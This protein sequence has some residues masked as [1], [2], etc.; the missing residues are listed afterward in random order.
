MKSQ[1]IW[2]NVL[3]SSALFALPAIAGDEPRSD[4]PFDNNSQQAPTLLSEFDQPRTDAGPLVG[5]LSQAPIESE[6]EGP[7]E[8]I[9]VTGTRTP[10]AVRRSP[11]TVNVITEREIDETLVR[12]LRDLFRYEPNIGVGANRRYG[13]QDITIRGLGSN[14]VLIQTDGIR[15]PN[16][17]TFGTPAIGRDYIELETLQR[18]EVIRGPA[19]ALY[20]SDALGGVVTFRTIEPVDLLT[21]FGKR[22]SLSVLSTN[23][24][25]ADRGFVFNGLTAHRVGNLEFL[26]GYTRR[27]AQEASIPGNSDFVDD[28][29]LG[30]NNYLGKFV[31]RLSQTS[32]LDFT[33]ERFFNFD[34]FY[35]SALTARDLIGP[36]GFRGQDETIDY[37]TSRSR[38]SLS[39]NF[40]DPN[41]RGF[42]SAAKLQIYYQNAKVEEER[43]QDFVRT[44]AGADR[45]R[46]RELDNIFVDRI[47][48]GNV[49]LQSN[50]KI[51]TV[52]NRLTYGFDLSTTRNERTRD[53]IEQRFNAAG[54]R[55]LSTTVIGAD[56]FPV[57][58]FPDSDTLR[59]GIYL[60][61]EIEF[62]NTFTL[63][64]GLRFDSYRLDT[65]PDA[66]YARNPG[67][68]AADFSSSAVSPSVGFV[69]QTT[70][71]LAI[72]GRYA[73]GF[74]AP[75]YSEIN[76]G[77]TNLT[78]PAFRYK[79]LSNPDL[80]PETSNGFEL[81]VR[82][83]FSQFNFSL[84]GF[85]NSYDNFIERLGNVGQSFTLVPG[86]PVT[87]FQSRNV[88][89]ARTYGVE[90]SGQ[91]RFSPKPHGLSLLASLGWT[92]GDDLT[93]DQPLESVEP[94]K[95]V[96]GLRYRAPENRWGADLVG[97]FVAQP[98]LS[99]NRPA[100]SF[101]P[102]AYTVVDLIGFYNLTPLI[103]F[104]VG[105]FNLFN[106]EYFEYQD[107]RPLL[108]A[109]APRDL[110]RYAQ[111]GISIR[112]GFT[113][114]F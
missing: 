46:L 77:F 61:N 29:D 56:N 13:I 72:V 15:A 40:D 32:S 103:S 36:T 87:L 44:G 5:P 45:R 9:T 93:T 24:E 112:A 20:G 54:S 51:G 58:D 11:A 62:G 78:S 66:I 113:Y 91:Y 96:V 30:R 101:T 100:G 27:D 6:S 52:A 83:G 65:S 17:F 4:H 79:T 90:L 7:E 60:Q 88:A 21:Q 110:D 57:K 38:F 108:N 50:F 97:S 85:Y 34:Q 23:F 86:F 71:S 109:A 114:R 106:T 74:R 80:E 28:R 35:V 67:A 3:L 26:L 92:V 42:L 102:S 2:F 81:G 95:A 19:S 22:D 98:R 63:I 69:W 73:R 53:G 16:Q 84:T 37:T 55:I 10:R 107:V 59:F 99:D 75:L 49:Q 8:E 82:G 12:D 64:P 76:A 47:F 41:S 89:K 48:G 25:S 94:F 43:V 1:R 111:P 104:N 70:P 68:V 39:Y 14:R 18:A 105:V 31:Y 33:A